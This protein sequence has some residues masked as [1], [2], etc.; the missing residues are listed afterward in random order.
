MPFAAFLYRD[1]VRVLWSAGWGRR[2]VKVVDSSGSHDETSRG[3]FPMGAG[4]ERYD[5]WVRLPTPR[6]PI[7]VVVD[8][9]VWEF[10]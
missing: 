6:V 4:S 5:S 2:E 3:T 9:Q 8:A 1:G 10:E 7:R